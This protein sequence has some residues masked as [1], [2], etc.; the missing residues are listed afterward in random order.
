L[1]DPSDALLDAV[2]SPVREYLRQRRDT[3]KQDVLT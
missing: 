3:V 2:A 1:L